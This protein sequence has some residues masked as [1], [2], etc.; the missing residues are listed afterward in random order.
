M[1]IEGNETKEQ[2]VQLHINF[3]ALTKVMVYTHVGKGPSDLGTD[4]STDQIRQKISPPQ[5][6]KYICMLI[7]T[8]TLIFFMLPE[9]LFPQFES[10]IL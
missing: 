9:A 10:W 4:R 1:P 5:M 3:I 7:N 8:C 2:A 6:N